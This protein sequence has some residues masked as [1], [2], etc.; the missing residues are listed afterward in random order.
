MLSHEHL[1]KYHQTLSWLEKR[2]CYIAAAVTRFGEPLLTEEVGTAYVAA[3]DD[4]LIFGFDRQWFDQL[5]T[6]ELVGVLVH[7]TMHVVH[8]HVFV[9]SAFHA[10]G[11][12]H[13]YNLACDAVVND[14]INHHYPEIVLPGEP[15]TGKR[16]IGKST[17][18]MTAEQVLRLLRTTAPL[19][20]TLSTLDDHSVWNDR[21]GITAGCGGTQE[22]IKRIIEAVERWARSDRWGN[23][24]LGQIREFRE[25]ET[26]FDWESFLLKKVGSKLKQ[27]TSWVPP[28]RRLSAFYPKIILPTY[29]I[30]ELR[31]VLLAIDASGSISTEILG[32]FVSLAQR[33]LKESIVET[34]SFDVGIYP[35][36]P[37]LHRTRPRGGGGTSFQAIERFALSKPH[38]PDA[39]VVFTD[40]QAPRPHLTHPERWIWCLSRPAPPKTLRGLGECISLP[41]RIVH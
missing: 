38:Y 7:E 25:K 10:G 32:S 9:V 16:L 31:R 22:L 6:N 33:Q 30:Q 29:A 20:P 13:L 21:T 26:S 14:L 17:L 28:N 11:D 40:G 1:E 39:V 41:L 15:V 12:A 5:N 37:C 24:V 18:G 4:K 8:R 23:E 19:T 3:M 34:I 36:T 35:F 27:E 2:G